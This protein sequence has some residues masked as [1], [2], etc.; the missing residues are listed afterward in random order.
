M[1]SFQIDPKAV[2]QKVPI[3]DQ[4][5][6]FQVPFAM[7]I[8]GPSQGKISG[9]K[10]SLQKNFD[11]DLDFSDNVRLVIRTSFLQ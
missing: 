4:D 11:S 10:N 5:L 7:S 9:S 3:N 1:T 6:S 8:T 2:V